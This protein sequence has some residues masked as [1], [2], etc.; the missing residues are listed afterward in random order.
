MELAVFEGF[1]P[2]F[3]DWGFGDGGL[4]FIVRARVFGFLASLYGCRGGGEYFW[5]GWE[6]LGGGG[7]LGGGRGSGRESKFP[8]PCPAPSC[9]LPLPRSVFPGWWQGGRF[10]ESESFR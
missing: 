10:D 1:Q 8:P 5:R 4:P 6:F 2:P 3:E 9:L 7:G